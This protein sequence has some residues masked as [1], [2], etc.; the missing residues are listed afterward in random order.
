MLKVASS[1]V[2]LLLSDT[3]PGKLFSALY[4]LSQCI[5]S[6]QLSLVQIYII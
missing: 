1:V 4:I 6:M 3:I 5:P 2:L